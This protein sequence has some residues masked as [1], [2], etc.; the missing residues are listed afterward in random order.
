MNYAKSPGF[1]SPAERRVRERKRV[2]FLLDDDGFS[3]L[4]RASQN[5][6]L[7]ACTRRLN[8]NGTR[9]DA[10]EK[11]QHEAKL[12]QAK[13][14]DGVRRLPRKLSLKAIFNAR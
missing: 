4:Q 9:W 13:V 3:N 7:W 1:V 14:V 11:W 5:H 10:F 8:T 2:N 12:A 6:D